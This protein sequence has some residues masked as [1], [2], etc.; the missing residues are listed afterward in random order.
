M[1]SS[2]SISRR[3]K[4]RF[5]FRRITSMLRS[6]F[7]S[8]L[9][10]FSSTLENYWWASHMD[11]WVLFPNCSCNRSKISVDL[12]PSFAKNL[13]KRSER[14]PIGFLPSWYCPSTRSRS[15]T[16][17]E[18]LIQTVPFIFDR[19]SYSAVRCYLSSRRWLLWAVVNHCNQTM[20]VL[21][22]LFFHKRRPL[23]LFL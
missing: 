16:V 10:T 19:L 7:S 13:L 8:S 14:L 2:S 12:T 15:I 9:S 11:Y 17:Q 4:W 18:L 20:C 22:C 6:H 5:L 3:V 21:L 1:V 23:C